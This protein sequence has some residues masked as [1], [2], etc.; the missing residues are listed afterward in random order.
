MSARPRAG[1][2]GA[3]SGGGTLT[4][5]HRIA[6][7]LACLVLLGA[8]APRVG[9]AAPGGVALEGAKAEVQAPAGTAWTKATAARTAGEWEVSW[10]GT[11]AHL[12][13]R[14]FPVRD[15]EEVEK[16]L[17]QAGDAVSREMKGDGFGLP[18]VRTFALDGHATA[19]ADLW[20]QSGTAHLEGRIRLLR[21]SPQAWA[22]A[23]G[24]AQ[25]DAEK[26]EA[27]AAS[28]FAGT[29]VP[30]EPAF[31]EPPGDGG[32][33]E[34]AVVAVAGEP[35]VVVRHLRAALALLEAGTGS[36]LARGSR[37][38]ALS[39]LAQQA[40]DDGPAARALLRAAADAC[41]ESEGLAPEARAQAREALGKRLLE[42]LKVRTATGQPG[43]NPLSVLFAAAARTVV[44]TAP[45][46]LTGAEVEAW[47]DGSA[48]LASLAA[49][50]EVT[51]T[52]EQRAVQ[53]EGLAAR[54]EG[55]TAVER[56]AARAAAAAGVDP[57]AAWAAADGAR[58]FAC[59]AA[60][61]AALLP[62]RPPETTPDP[63][64][65]MP[66]LRRRLDAATRDP[67]TVWAAACA[68]APAE[69]QRLFSLL[70]GAGN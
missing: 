27:A 53:R 64:L 58:R 24:L 7:R 2:W 62:P 35:G 15:M 69:Q 21:A 14:V 49:D 68:L 3:A 67:A 32:S 29:L 11:K 56:T 34:E 33:P 57:A 46:G 9:L 63:A 36:R 20:V 52:P 13:A 51:P 54:W 44:G 38:Q 8:L 48:W 22:L 19:E 45:E 18:G 23:W 60:V 59:R 55:W 41:A 40:R 5:M 10:R 42:A 26:A 4:G 61:V 47:L 66:T 31:F 70:S 1:A 17:W 12:E 37:T 39:L 43:V 65:D 6:P 50:G 16:V 30:S 28:A 25:A